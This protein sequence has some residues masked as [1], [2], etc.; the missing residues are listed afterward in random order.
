MGQMKLKI[1]AFMDNLMHEE[2]YIIKQEILSAYGNSNK[3][4][5]Y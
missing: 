2:F 3:Y 5:T 4:A 1:K